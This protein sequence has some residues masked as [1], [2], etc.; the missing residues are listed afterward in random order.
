VLDEREQKIFDIVN[1]LNVGRGLI[2]QQSERDELAE[3]N[4]VAG[5]R[6]KA[7]AA[8]EV[9]HNYL[10]IGL[11]LL[12]DDCWERQYDLA[13]TLHVGAAE[14]TYLSGN[15]EQAERLIAVVLQ[16]AKTLLDKVRAYEVH[17]H[18]YA[19]QHKP[20]EAIKTG[21]QV[22]Q[23]LG[24]SFPEKPSQVDVRASLEET[25]LTLAGRS[26]EELI[27]L[28]KM[29]DPYQLATMRL[30]SSVLHGTYVGFPEL[31]PLVASNMVNLSAKYGNTTLSA[32]AYA[33]YGLILCGIVGD[34]DAGYRFGKLA[35]NLVEQF[36]AKAL[37]SITI[38]MVNS[39]IRHW[40]GH[41]KTTLQPLLEGYQSGLETGDLLSAVLCVFD[42]GFQS[43]WMGKELSGLERELAKY[44]RVIDQLKQKQILYV[45]ELYRQAVLNLLGKAQDPCRLVGASYHEEKMLPR[46]L[47]AN[48]RNA[49]CQI[50]LNKLL[51]CYLFQDYS[52]AMR[53]AA[54]TETHLESL[55]STAAVPAFYL[56]DSLARLAILPDVQGAEQTGFLEKVATNQE[57]M[58]L[59]AQHAPMNYLHKF[60]LV[61]AERARVLGRDGEAREYYDQA[62]TLAQEHEYL[63]EE[64]LAYELAGRFYLA[65]GQSHLARYYLRDAHYAYQQWGAVAKVKDLEARYPQV[66]AQAMPDFVRT[67]VSIVTTNMGQRLSGDFD[68]TSVLKA[69]QAIS[70]EIVLD[71]LLT[72]LMGLVI[73][74]AGAQRGFLILE[75]NGQLVIE[76]EGTIDKDGVVVLQSVPVETS[77]DLPTA[78][79]RYVERTKETVV[80]SDA[81]QEDAFASDPYIIKK[82]PKSVLCAPLVTQG[83][84]TGILYLENNL[85]TG[86]F[87]PDRLEV[88]NLLSAEAAISIENARLYKNL[89]EA[90]KRL[91]DY[92]KTLEL[93]VEQRTQELQERNRELEIA[94]QQA[95]EATRRKSQ[96]LA[97]MSHELRTPMN[98]IIGFTRLVLRRAGDGLPERQRDNLIKVQESANHLL[99]LINELLDLSKIEAGRMEVRPVLFDV[100]QFVLA[101]CETMYPLVK[102]DVQLR[103][104]ISGEVREAH[105]DEE[106][107]RHIVLNLLSNAIKFT[108]A[109]EVVVRVRMDGRAD[110]SASLVI[111]VADTGVGIAAEALGAIFE[112]FQQVGGSTQNHKGTGLGLPI[113]RRWAE[114]LGG[115]I[116]VESE[117]GKGSTFTVTIPLAYQQ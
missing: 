28:P 66:L 1:H 41:I 71:R 81:T 64:A 111:A 100:R 51:L 90:N 43:Y 45:N 85:V 32:P 56:Y 47:R 116:G 35:L 6:A 11:S 69:S 60:Y 53:N 106:G 79:V 30:L 44:S 104:E 83:K 22:L 107:L 86:T 33:A 55:A 48:D 2:R 14:V 57:K 75:E 98:A 50:Y 26:I 82:Q 113:A 80:L 108:D 58:K 10:Q 103:H 25:K 63:N 89:E 73:E 31:F 39:F 87:T 95:L 102:P 92:S 37:K 42:Y 49:L 109:G 67:A 8:Y 65:R 110:N 77:P 16:Q 114:L 40:K 5:K 23:L 38:F 21:L 93:K 72:T 3:L 34:I 12:R 88:L 36:N 46:H 101:C 115:S 4:L 24:V 91:E 7:A 18:A 76:A 61:E 105:T 99:N 96:F 19:A 97:G 27:D 62:I 78:V 9:A 20:L 59:W 15:L 52:G 29:T 68:F 74:N 94:N 84:L 54:L 17:H 117:R 13:L 70:S 112:E